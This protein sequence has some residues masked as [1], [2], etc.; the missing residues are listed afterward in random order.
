[1]S[2]NRESCI[3][4]AHHLARQQFNV[5]LIETMLELKPAGIGSAEELKKIL[6]L[7]KQPFATAA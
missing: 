6:G 4:P 2:T 7:A 3:E 1:L 5:F